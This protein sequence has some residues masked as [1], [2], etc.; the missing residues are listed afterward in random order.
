MR[1]HYL[2]TLALSALL[3]MSTAYSPSASADVEGVTA[4]VIQEIG[5]PS[6][7]DL[8]S[9]A[10]DIDGKILAAAEDIET[11]R[12]KL[13]KALGAA[14]DVKF[15]TAVADFKAKA[16]G[17]IK[18]ETDGGKIKIGFEPDAPDDIKSAAAA[19]NDAVENLDKAK[20]KLGQVPGMIKELGDKATAAA[21]P[22]NV[23]SEATA[24]GLKAK[25]V[26]AK[27]KLIRGNNQ[28]MKVIPDNSKAVVGEA[29]KTL[30]LIKTIGS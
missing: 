8:Y 9:Q 21:D 6:F 4:V 11:T 7:D 1:T 10:Q 26:P 28:A 12:K 5:I 20:E 23:K 18:I 22:K 24:A 2:C 30:E 27:L 25:E 13:K 19:M 14:E 16:P 29:D 15:D 17:M 3:T